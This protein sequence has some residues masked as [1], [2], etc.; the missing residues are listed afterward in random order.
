MFKLDKKYWPLIKIII[1]LPVRQEWDRVRE[2]GEYRLLYNDC[3]W[4][5][6]NGKHECIIYIELYLDCC[7]KWIYIVRL[8]Y[9]FYRYCYTNE[10]SKAEGAKI[11]LESLCQYYKRFRQ[12]K[13]YE[14]ARPQ[15]TFLW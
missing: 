3:I 4:K 5:G 14:T 7:I 12:S 15:Q 6:G 2:T 1:L 13:I 11:K 9:T 10:Y 8:L